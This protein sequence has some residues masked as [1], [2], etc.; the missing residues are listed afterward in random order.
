MT[1]PYS[2][3]QIEKYLAQ[4]IRAFNVFTV[5]DGVARNGQIKTEKVPVIFG[6][7]SRVIAA[8]LSNDA[9]F[10]NV[11]VP[12]MSVNL[13][14]LERDEES[15]LNRYHEN[16]LT[17]RRKEGEPR[18]VNRIVGV[19]LRMNIDLHIYASSVSQLMELVEQILLVFNP[20]VAIQKSTDPRDSDYITSIRLESLAP[21]ITSPLGSA[22][23]ASEMTMSFSVPI[24]IS[25]PPMDKDPLESIR[26]SVFTA[27]NGE[28]DSETELKDIIESEEVIEEPEDMDYG[29]EV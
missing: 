10:R 17:F 18:N 22:N 4:V 19:P 3:K 20:E 15:T 9:K 5:S 16:E 11:K 27:D 26:V 14:S 24:R 28:K 8:I 7:P 2:E 12:M 1:A 6:S 29:S 21:N 25:Y 13:T 23:R